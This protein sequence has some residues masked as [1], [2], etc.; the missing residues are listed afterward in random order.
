M[1]GTE[2][3][4]DPAQPYPHLPILTQEAEDKRF[5]EIYKGQFSL[6]KRS[7]LVSFHP[8]SLL[9]FGQKPGMKGVIQESQWEERWAIIPAF[10]KT[11]ED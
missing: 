11:T 2:L 6:T 7:V 3:G 8:L 10:L 4:W 1:P 9:F 5:G